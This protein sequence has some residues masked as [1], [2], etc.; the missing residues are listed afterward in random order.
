MIAAKQKMI[1][2]IRDQPED[3]AFDEILHE[4][5]FARMIEKGL[6]D[7]D[8]GRV[9]SNDEMKRRIRLWQK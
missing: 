2:I 9:I 6:A 3:S 4:L 5:A 1:E 8:N 7:S